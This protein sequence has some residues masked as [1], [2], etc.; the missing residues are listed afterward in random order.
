MLT[1]R[2][3]VSWAITLAVFV[4]IAG[5]T[6]RASPQQGPGEEKG[7]V[8][9]VGKGITPPRPLKRVDPEYTEEARDAKLEGVVVVYVVIGED[10]R[11]HDIRVIRSLG[12][13]LDEKAIEA[14]EQWEFEPGKKDGKPVK[15]GATIEINFRLN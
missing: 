11:A 1:A 2:Q 8:Y 9:R 6:A 15:V 7:G 14:V 12:K 4:G 13:G 10:G 3:V 5:F